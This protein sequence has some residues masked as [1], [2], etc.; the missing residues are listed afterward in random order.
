MLGTTGML[1]D[2][3]NARPR[4]Q[5]SHRRAADNR[6]HHRTIEVNGVKLFYRE[7]GDPT[8]P[9]LLLLHGFPSSSHMFR[10]LLP[11]LA[12]TYHLIAPDFP[13]FGFSPL[14]PR[15][16]FNASFAGYAELLSAFVDAVGL[17]HF[18]LY[19]HDYGAAIG[20]RLALKSPD[21]IRFLIVQNGN[22]YAE[23]L[24]PLFDALRA[25]WQNPTPAGRERLKAL[26]APAATKLQYEAGLSKNQIELISP[27]AWEL[28][29]AIIAKPGRQELNLDLFEDFRTNVELYPQFQ[30]LLRERRYRTQIAW[31][32]KDPVFRVEGARAYLR[33]IPHAEF[34]LLDGSHFLLET[35]GPEVFGLM[36]NFARRLR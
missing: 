5:Q 24:S 30:A 11:A 34:H 29:A 31:G 23:G 15:E 7:A 10:H 21:S 25:H 22:A 13:G 9:T 27:E 18:G 1:V 19:L 2:A 14:P 6:V 33:D 35:N 4:S 28:D 26:I 12:D 3:A 36:R 8:L 17:K 16:R 20:L 32:A